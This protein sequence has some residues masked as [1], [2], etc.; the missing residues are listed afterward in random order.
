MN[1][2]DIE[3]QNIYQEALK[4]GVHR[5]RDHVCNPGEGEG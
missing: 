2:P 5:G 1:Y 4:A 3:T